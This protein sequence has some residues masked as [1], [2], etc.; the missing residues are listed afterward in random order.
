MAADVSLVVEIENFWTTKSVT[1]TG[2]WTIPS[3]CSDSALVSVSLVRTPSD[4]APWTKKFDLH[5]GSPSQTCGLLAEVAVRVTRS[6]V[7]AP[8]FTE[9]LAR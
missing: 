8:E 6:I 7:T 4:P 1:L 5:P 2:Q 3:P 9:A